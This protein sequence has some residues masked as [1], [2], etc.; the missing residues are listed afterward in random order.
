MLLGRTKGGR[1]F[2]GDREFR[3]VCH[4]TRC[5]CG[6]RLNILSVY[7]EGPLS[8]TFAASDLQHPLKSPARQIALAMLDGEKASNTI[9][10]L[11]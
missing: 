2:V 4:H 6:F 7:E 1:R 5:M 3:C 10:L 8:K 11:F 9:M